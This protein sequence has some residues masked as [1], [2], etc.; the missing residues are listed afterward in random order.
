MKFARIAIIGL[1]VLAFAATVAQADE[2]TDAISTAQSAYGSG[3]YKEASTQ[4]QTALVG[5]NQKLIDMIVDHLPDAPSGWTAEDPEGM[6]ASAMGAGFFAALVVSR[7]YYPP[8]GSS[9]EI[10]IAANSPLLATYHMF[11]S[12]PM[13]AAMAGQSGMKKVSVCGY[14]AMEQFDDGTYDLNILA[15]SATLISVS[16]DKEDDIDY[17]RQLANL[18]DCEG[19]VSVV[20]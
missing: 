18:I 16:G 1:T 15:G 11:I 17:I 6:D 10:V 4:L 12:N 13:M 7:S 5:V 8:N 2:V 19:I 3:N 20:E 14:D 9:I